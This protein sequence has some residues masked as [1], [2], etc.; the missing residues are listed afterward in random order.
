[1]GDRELRGQVEGDVV[2]TPNEGE[3]RFLVAAPFSPF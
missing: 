1:M 2:G 3:V